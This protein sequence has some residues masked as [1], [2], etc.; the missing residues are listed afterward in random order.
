MLREVGINWSRRGER[1]VAV[2]LTGDRLVDLCD[3][4]FREKTNGRDGNGGG[5]VFRLTG[6]STA[7]AYRREGRMKK[8]V[9]GKQ[10]N[11]QTLQGA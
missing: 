8:S 3:S 5:A 11:A 7:M 9:E 2:A 10:L 4:I 6:I 1:S